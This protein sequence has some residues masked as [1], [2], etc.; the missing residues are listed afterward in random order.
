MYMY[1]VVIQNGQ[2]VGRSEQSCFPLRNNIDFL[3]IVEM[4]I[5]NGSFSKEMF[6][7]EEIT[8]ETPKNSEVSKRMNSFLPHWKF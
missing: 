3:G 5:N 2:W 4:A 7:Q 8:S 6:L 1:I